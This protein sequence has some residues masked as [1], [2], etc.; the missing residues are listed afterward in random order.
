[1]LGKDYE[2]QN[3]AIASSLEVL[4]ERW[5]LLIVRDAFLGVRRFNDFAARLDIPRAVL[6]ERLR[7]LTVNG[8]LEKRPDPERS[9]RHLYELTPAGR[10]LW[11]MLYDL[12]S[13]GSEHRQRS[14][15][16]YRHAGCGTELVTGARC[17]R[18]GIT[19]DPEDVLKVPRRGTRPSREDPVSVAIHRKR[20]LL[21][22]LEPAL[23]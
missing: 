2:N 18:C 5:T 17:P 15:S 7:S 10:K 9:G 11:P 16:V 20:R 8:I 3:C 22:P 4:G 19:P 23:G 14:S 13:W 12:I 1:M 6:S 21:E